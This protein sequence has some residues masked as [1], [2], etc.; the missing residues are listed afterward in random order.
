[1]SIFVVIILS[2]SLSMD[3]FSLSLAY[4]TLNLDK[5]QIIILST[6][7]GIYHLFMPLIGMNIGNLILSFLPINPNLIVFVVLFVIGLQMIIESFNNDKSI[8]IMNFLELLI[9]GLAVSID[10]FSIGIGLKAIYR[11]PLV[12]AITFSLSSFIFTY[13]GLILGKKLNNLIGKISTMF[14]GIILI[15]IGIIYLI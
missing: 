8:K 3:A 9:F 15:L 14:G 2:I 7:V 13:L 4:G 12:A 1:M 5:K 11:N 10:S 6:I